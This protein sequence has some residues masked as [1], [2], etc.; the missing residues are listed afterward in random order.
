MLK[1]KPNMSTKKALFGLCRAI[2]IKYS[3]YELLS[4]GP[5]QNKDTESLLECSSYFYF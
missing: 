2:N 5:K 1:S 3:I 4:D